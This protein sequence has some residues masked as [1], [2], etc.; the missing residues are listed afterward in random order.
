[1]HLLHTA[2]GAD[3]RSI[4]IVVLETRLMVVVSIR[5]GLLL[6]GL[7]NFCGDRPSPPLHFMRPEI[8]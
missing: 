3:A 6:L 1:M 4:V 5:S 7:A 8:I 2:K